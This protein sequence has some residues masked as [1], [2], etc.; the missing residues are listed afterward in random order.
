VRS[1]QYLCVE[2]CLHEIFGI[3]SGA[4]MI[5]NGSTFRLTAV[6]ELDTPISKLSRLARGDGRLLLGRSRVKQCSAWAVEKM[7]EELLVR[8]EV[9]QHPVWAR[10][11][12]QLG[13][14]DHKSA[15]NQQ[16]YKQIQAAQIILA[17]SIPV[18]S[19]IGAAS[20]Q[21]I[22]AIL[23]ASVAILAGFQ[24]LGNYDD[25]WTTYRAI[26]EQLRHEKYLFL[27]QSG[28]YRSLQEEEALRLL[29]ERVEER[30][31]TEHAK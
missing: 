6:S 2:T 14:Y 18:F 30:V 24:Q 8:E 16:R 25:L 3:G 27:A 17:T 23:G 10:L 4:T 13:W 21:W 19:L 29:A 7:T 26:A 1:R 15:V 22:T 20:G 31:S 12:D 5:A 11:N 9:E 28:P